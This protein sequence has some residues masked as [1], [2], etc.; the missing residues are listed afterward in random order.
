M[1]PAGLEYATIRIMQGFLGNPGDES[2][3]QSYRGSA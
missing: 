2:E 3:M 1:S